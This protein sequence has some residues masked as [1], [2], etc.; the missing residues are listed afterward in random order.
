M[1]QLQVNLRRKPPDLYLD[2]PLHKVERGWA[3]GNLKIC[4]IP[5]LA[6]AE[7]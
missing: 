7:F 6:R 4:A 1:S 2:L 3:A 5:L